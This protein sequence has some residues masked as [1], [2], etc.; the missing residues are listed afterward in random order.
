MRILHMC[1]AKI[2]VGGQR[3]RLEPKVMVRMRANSLWPLLS[4]LSAASSA[5]TIEQRHRI[6]SRDRTCAGGERGTRISVRS[7][8]RPSIT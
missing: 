1:V 7:G 4:G 2:L 6:G 3:D 8:G 5:T